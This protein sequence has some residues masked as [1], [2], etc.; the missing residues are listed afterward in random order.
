MLRETHDRMNV[1]FLFPFGVFCFLTQSIRFIMNILYSTRTPTLKNK[2]PENYERK[3]ISLITKGIIN[4][5]GV[6]P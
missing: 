6:N 5:H 4:Q 2:K 1:P 3:Y